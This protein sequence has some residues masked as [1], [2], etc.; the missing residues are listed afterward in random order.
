MKSLQFHKLIRQSDESVEEWMG[1]LRMAVIK[2][3]YKERDRQLKE[4]FI[5]DLNDEEMLAEIIRELTKCDENTT[6]HS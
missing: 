5:H 2:C 3:N 1:R 4:Q 6:I